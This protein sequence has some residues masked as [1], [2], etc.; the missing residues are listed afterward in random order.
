MTVKKDWAK[1]EL[2]VLRVHM[3]EATRLYGP[4]ED[5]AWI[6]GTDNYHPHHKS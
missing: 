5:E 2:E 4:P 6:E 3:T 1:P